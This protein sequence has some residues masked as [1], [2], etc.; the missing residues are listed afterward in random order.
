MS[1]AK[2][3]TAMALAASLAMF[4]ACS[5]TKYRYIKEVQNTETES[6]LPAFA[7]HMQGSKITASDGAT[8][9]NFR[10]GGEISHGNDD[11]D[12][13]DGKYVSCAGGVCE[14]VDEADATRFS[15]PASAGAA[16]P[17]ITVETNGITDLDGLATALDTAATGTVFATAATALGTIYTGGHASVITSLE[18]EITGALSSV[19]SGDYEGLTNAEAVEAAT[20]AIITAVNG[21]AVLLANTKAELDKA[22]AL[23]E[24]LE[25]TDG[26]TEISATA[27]S[28]LDAIDGYTL[29]AEGIREGSATGPIVVSAAILSYLGFEAYDDEL[30]KWKYTTASIDAY[31]ATAALTT[32][33]T[34]VSATLLA[35]YDAGVGEAPPTLKAT[36]LEKLF[37]STVFGV[38]ST[39]SEINLDLGINDKTLRFSSF[40]YK[41]SSGQSNT[42][43][44]DG[45]AAADDSLTGIT[46]SA[47]SG[48]NKNAEEAPDYVAANGAAFVDLLT[49]AGHDFTAPNSD[50]EAKFTGRSIAAL[51]VDGNFAQLDGNAELN[52]SVVGNTLNETL[53]LRFDGQW[54]DVAFANKNSAS[55]VFAENITLGDE[56]KLT[57][58]SGFDSASG[59]KA[60]ESGRFEA[61]YAGAGDISPAGIDPYIEATGTF[62][63]SDAG[64]ESGGSQFNKAFNLD[65]AFG[66][67]I[68]HNQQ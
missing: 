3:F 46:I 31:F 39:T 45:A 50:V 1:L 33:T 52:F 2:T 7:A 60:A 35:A 59:G 34:D 29:T 14:E 48:Y 64:T 25:A 22:F 8:V 67:V 16:D 38:T 61:K 47:F 30:A 41:A 66:A 55:I 26:F 10:N 6:S 27:F 62:A 40:G 24:N 5:D 12:P 18:G 11:F 9:V 58:T 28:S 65:G 17:V 23:L 63:V 42:A 56:F 68:D 54:Y 51:Q 49:D 37:A 57:A 36:G 4:P 32:K 13:A 20:G 53:D 43:E 19:Q 21:V 15:I 44:E